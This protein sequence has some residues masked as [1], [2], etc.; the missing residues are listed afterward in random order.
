MLFRSGL[1][2]V[3]AF[4][5]GRDYVIPGDVKYVWVDA[6]AHR[7]VLPAG[8]EVS[9]ERAAQIAEAVLGSVRPPRLR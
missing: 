1:S 8:A 4:L 6:V 3:A 7:L 2:R 9:W 5:K